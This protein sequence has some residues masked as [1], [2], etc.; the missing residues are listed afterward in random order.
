M[1]FS[2]DFYPLTMAA[3]FLDIPELL[4]ACATY[5]ALLVKDKPQ[6]EIMKNLK[7]TPEGEDSMLSECKDKLRFPYCNCCKIGV[8]NEA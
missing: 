2:Y 7:L 3:N 8:A 4:D 1:D 6:L 5:Y